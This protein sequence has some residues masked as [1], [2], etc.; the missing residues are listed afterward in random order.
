MP[1]RK[2]IGQGQEGRFI[3]PNPVSLAFATAPQS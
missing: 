2:A 1:Q 3:L